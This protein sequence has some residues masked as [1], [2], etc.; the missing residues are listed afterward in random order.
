M[1]GR[2]AKETTKTMSCNEQSSWARGSGRNQ[3]IE[4]PLRSTGR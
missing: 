3:E 2:E 4:I 1:L